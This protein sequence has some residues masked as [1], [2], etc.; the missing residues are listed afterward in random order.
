MWLKGEAFE[1][2]VVIHTCTHVSPPWCRAQF[3]A[4]RKPLACGPMQH[5]SFRTSNGRL[6]TSYDTRGS[7]VPANLGMSRSWMLNEQ[8][9]ELVP[10]KKS[11]GEQGVCVQCRKTCCFHFLDIF[12][13]SFFSQEPFFIGPRFEILMTVWGIPS[14]CDNS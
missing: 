9:I 3:S 8:R 2:S 14:P 6:S 12:S 13:N 5:P 11:K 4:Q 10:K 1:K 7:K